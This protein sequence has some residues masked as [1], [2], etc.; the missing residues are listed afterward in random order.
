MENDPV[1]IQELEKYLPVRSEKER[2][3]YF[4]CVANVIPLGF[5]KRQ[6]FRWKTRL[7]AQN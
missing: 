4:L 6:I 3:I 5:S 7:I 1:K 2:E